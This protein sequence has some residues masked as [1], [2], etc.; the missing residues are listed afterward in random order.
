MAV[1]A[2]S[3]RGSLSPQ[4]QKAKKPNLFS[5]WIYC[6]AQSS[7]CPHLSCEKNNPNPVYS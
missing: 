5:S 4:I 1:P 7:W 2:L 3:R 6:M